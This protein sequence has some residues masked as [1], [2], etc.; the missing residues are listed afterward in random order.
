L[1]GDAAELAKPFSWVITPNPTEPEDGFRDNSLTS[2]IQS[3]AL[4]EKLRQLDQQLDDL[5]ILGKILA[6]CLLVM[7]SAILILLE[8]RCEI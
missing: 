1:G 3:E 7:Y 4:E 2:K 5:R 8:R 6:S